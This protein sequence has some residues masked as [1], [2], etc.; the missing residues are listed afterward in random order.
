MS[1]GDPL[2]VYSRVPPYRGCRYDPKLSRARAQVPPDRHPTPVTRRPKRPKQI[3][4]AY[5]ALSDL[6]KKTLY[7]EFRRGGAARGLQRPT[8]FASTRSAYGALAAR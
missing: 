4:Q 3:N 1:D 8:S 7:D 2:P 6:K 5:D